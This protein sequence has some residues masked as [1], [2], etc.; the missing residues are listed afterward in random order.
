MRFLH[1]EKVVVSNI[2]DIMIIE[3]STMGLMNLGCDSAKSVNDSIVVLPDS[4][5][6]LTASIKVLMIT[7]SIVVKFLMNASPEMFAKKIVTDLI[8]QAFT[9]KA[10]IIL[11]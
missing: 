3:S 2:S 5:S 8:V 10:L 9:Y 1:S 7:G 4:S 11:C 6:V